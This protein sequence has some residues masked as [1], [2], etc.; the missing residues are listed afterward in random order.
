MAADE[1][2]PDDRPLSDEERR[3]I[4][5]AE[6]ALAALAG[7]YRAAAEADLVRLR[8]A[9]ADLAADPAA[10]AVHLERV[11]TIAH[12]MKGQGATFGRPRVTEIGERLCRFIRTRRET[13]DDADVA[14]VRR[15][16]EALAK[17]FR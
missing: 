17:E 13:L 16:V 15:H 8:A 12:D 5:R 1:T 14:E 9:A 2:L 10:R 11:F 3:A 7:H 6:A 4:A